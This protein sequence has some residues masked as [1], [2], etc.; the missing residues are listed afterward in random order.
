M[1]RRA[2]L[3]SQAIAEQR[4]PETTGDAQRTENLAS[5]IFTGGPGAGKTIAQFG[6]KGFKQTVRTLAGLR[7]ALARQ[8]KPILGKSMKTLK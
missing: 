5:L 2:R 1:S 6:P 3:R 4:D 8:I 7:K